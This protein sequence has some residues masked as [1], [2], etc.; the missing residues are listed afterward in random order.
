MPAPQPEFVTFLLS[1]LAEVGDIS[2]SRF[3]GGWQLRAQDQ[4][5]AIVMKGTLFFRV[6]AALQIELEL[7][8]SKPFS[9]LKSGKATVVPKYMSAPDDV[10]DDLDLLRSWVRRVVT[11]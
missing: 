6:E 8:G 2:A 1:E 7:R 3:F 10:V 9:Y 4:Q 11:A 5:I